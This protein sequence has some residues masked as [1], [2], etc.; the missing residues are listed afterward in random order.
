M[1]K[2]P[3]ARVTML[4]EATANQVYNAFT[5]PDQLARFWLAKADGPLQIGQP[6]RWDFLIEGAQIVTIARRLDQGRFI[7]WDWSDGTS[8][9]IEL[10]GLDGGTAVTLVNGGFLGDD[11]E[12]IDAALNATQGFAIVLADLKTLLESG[13]SAGITKAKAKLISHRR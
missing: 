10:E 1:R 3:K 6:V 5:E 9:T 2:E 4:I 12:A 11:D 13:T 7:A 8:V